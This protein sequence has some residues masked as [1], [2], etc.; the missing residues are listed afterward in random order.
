MEVVNAVEKDI[1]F[2]KFTRF[3]NVT[4]Q[5]GKDLKGLL[6]D[7]MNQ[8]IKIKQTVLRMQTKMDIYC[9]VKK[10]NYSGEFS[11]IIGR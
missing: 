3:G 6:S 5:I 4:I 11:K 9:R 2:W 8:F 1:K 10:R 7:M